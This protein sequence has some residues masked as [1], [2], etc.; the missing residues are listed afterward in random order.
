MT[1]HLLSEIRLLLRS[2]TVLGVFRLLDLNPVL[3]KDL[4]EVFGR[5]LAIVRVPVSVEQLLGLLGFLSVPPDL[6]I[7]R[8]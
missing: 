2:L 3:L 1:Q 7:E 4:N 6:R 8:L 5:V